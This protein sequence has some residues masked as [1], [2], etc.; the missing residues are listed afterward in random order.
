MWTILHLK[1][2]KQDKTNTFSKLEWT[3]LSFHIY[4]V[5]GYKNGS[6]VFLVLLLPV[7][8]SLV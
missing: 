1:G 2:K 7:T 5:Y 4:S 6:F 8:I 3:K